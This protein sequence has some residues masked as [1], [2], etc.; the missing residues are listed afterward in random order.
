MNTEP[1]CEC[2]SSQFFINLKPMP[3]LDGK[4]VIIGEVVEGLGVLKSLESVGTGMNE[5]LKRQVIIERSGEL[6]L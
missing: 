5:V 1:N 6:P 4:N 3:W 2:Y